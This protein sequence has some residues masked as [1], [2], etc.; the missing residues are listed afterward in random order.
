[1][2]RS[3]KVTWP[4]AMG[5]LRV[6]ALFGQA[7]QMELYHMGAAWW[8]YD[9]ATR[10]TLLTLCDGN[11]PV[12]GGEVILLTKSKWFKVL[13]RSFIL[14]KTSIWTNN[15]VH[16]DVRRYDARMTSL[17]LVAALMV[18]V[19]FFIL[20]ESLNLL[21]FCYIT[22]S[23]MGDVSVA[24]LWNQLPV[25]NVFQINWYRHVPLETLICS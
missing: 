5:L 16:S 25:L 14:A 1:M 13:I 4:R 6:V 12:T 24:W 7:S 20:S 19:S 9:M 18:Y 23:Y 11:P 10:S 15:R 2:E 21:C 22:F 3:E 17:K 8:R